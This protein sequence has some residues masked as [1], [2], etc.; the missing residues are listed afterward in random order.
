MAVQAA[1]AESLDSC[2]AFGTIPNN[3]PIPLINCAHLLLTNGTVQSNLT[4]SFPTFPKTLT[5]WTH[6][7]PSKANCLHSI[8]YVCSMPSEHTVS[9][10]G[11]KTVCGFKTTA[12]YQER[13]V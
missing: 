12:S 4:Y 1:G 6:G 5:Q 10:G 13:L 7:N 8:A 3:N 9:L 2:Y 11:L